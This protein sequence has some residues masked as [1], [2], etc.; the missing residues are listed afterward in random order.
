MTQRTA[1]DAATLE[2]VA[3]VLQEGLVQDLAASSMY[4]E[5]LAHVVLSD[6]SA[7]AELRRLVEALHAHAKDA[8][9][10]RLRPARRPGRRTAPGVSGTTPPS[11]LPY[12]ARGGFAGRPGTWKVRC[13]TTMEVRMSTSDETR[14]RWATRV[15][16]LDAWSRELQTVRKTATLPLSSS[17]PRARRRGRVRWD[18]G[19]PELRSPSRSIRPRKR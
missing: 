19:H 14:R 6:A 10:P 2:S 1:H 8:L 11:S 7:G 3:P 5:T 4:A 9:A 12:G 15:C 13:P 16:Q 17:I 18:S